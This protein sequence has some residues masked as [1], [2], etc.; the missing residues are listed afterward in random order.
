M[1]EIHP[2]LSLRQARGP[3]H[4][5]WRA[6]GDAH[7]AA[8]FRRPPERVRAGR[9]WPWRDA[10]NG[11]RATFA[12]D[13]P[14]RVFK[15]GADTPLVVEFSLVRLAR[16]QRPLRPR[17]PWRPWAWP[18]LADRGLLG[19]L[20][21]D[22]GL[23]LGFD[24]GDQL[25]GLGL[26]LGRTGLEQ[27]EGVGAQAGQIG[28]GHGGKAGGHAHRKSPWRS[29][30]GGF[31]GP[32]CCAKWRPPKAARGAEFDARRLKSVALL[33]AQEAFLASLGEKG[34][35]AQLF[36]FRSG[37]EARKAARSAGV[38]TLALVWRETR[39]VGG[40]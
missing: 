6:G 4:P 34:P 23:D 31:L 20:G 9:V 18:C 16:P 22:A 11:A 5:G 40:A 26:L 27:A 28:V 8:Q 39:G 15:R 1:I 13:T 14:E 30:E 35:S 36:G 19:R 10:R 33:C 38:S 17:P 3:L 24:Q 29:P 25:L 12:P 37:R 7:L 2:F 21:G 32:D